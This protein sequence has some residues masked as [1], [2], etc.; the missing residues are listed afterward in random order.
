MMPGSA[1]GSIA[2]SVSWENEQPAPAT[3]KFSL[4]VIYG[5]APKVEY[6]PMRRAN[7]CSDPSGLRIDSCP[8]AVTTNDPSARGPARSMTPGTCRYGVH[9]T[10]DGSDGRGGGMGGSTG[11]FGSADVRSPVNQP[12]TSKTRS[13]S[14]RLNMDTRPRWPSRLTTRF[15]IVCPASSTFRLEAS[16]WAVAAG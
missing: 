15:G 8:D 3:A 16:G 13:M 2:K 12:A 6:P 9:W 4:S 1:P 10:R 11:T 14:L 7:G 5:S